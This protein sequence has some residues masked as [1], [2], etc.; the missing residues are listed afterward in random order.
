ML[1]DLKTAAET[2]MGEPVQEAIITCPA[3]FDDPQR[4]A[5]RSAG[6]MAGFKAVCLVNAPTAAALAYAVAKKSS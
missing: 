2:Y 5:T 1:R 3:C 4:R 6:L